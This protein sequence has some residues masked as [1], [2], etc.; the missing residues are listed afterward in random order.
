MSFFK[1]KNEIHKDPF[2]GI[3]IAQ[4]ISLELSVISIDDKFDIYPIIQRIW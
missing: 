2:D 1:F 3:I 4:S